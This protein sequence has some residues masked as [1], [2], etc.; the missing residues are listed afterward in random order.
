MPENQNEIEIRSDEVQ[1]I[2][3]NIPVWFIRWGITVI[4][5]IILLF[6]TLSYFIKYPDVISGSVTITTEI[7]PAKLVSKSSGEI[8]HLFLKDGIEVRK[9][10]VIAEIR[11]PITRD[12]VNYLNKR[13]FEIEEGLKQ[14]LSKEIKLETNQFTFG[15]LQNDYNALAK[16]IDQYQIDLN[17]NQFEKRKSILTRQISNYK[18]LA[19]INTQQIEYAQEDFNRA[20]EKFKSSQKLYQQN[21]ISK[22]DLYNEESAFNQIKNQIENLRKGDVQNSITLTDYERQLNDLEFDQMSKEIVLEREIETYLENIKNEVVN[23]EE[24]YFIKAPFD[25]TLNYLLPLAENQF[26]RAEINLFAIVPTDENYIGLVQLD[27]R[28]YGKVKVGQEVKIDLDNYPS[29][30][31]GRLNGEVESI[32]LLPNE[33]SYLIKIRL[34]EGLISSYNQKLVYTPEMLGKADVI[35]EDLRILER[36]F[37]Q[38]RQ[39]FDQ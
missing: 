29:N 13:I 31:F 38:F 14:G 7:P 6:V 32:A 10:D 3:S 8:Q 37:N 19:K 1:E 27:K 21:A 15:T 39:I 28:G 20:D 17:G 9:G 36:I 22:V 4:F 11:N 26:I 33:D 34:I 16:A 23:W 5:I 24:N 2:L 12:A 18:K 25:G 30:E 35:T